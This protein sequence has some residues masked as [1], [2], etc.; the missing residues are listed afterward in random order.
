MSAVLVL[1]LIC[2]DMAMAHSWYYYLFGV[3]SIIDQ[4]LFW[5]HKSPR[6]ISKHL[7]SVN[8]SFIVLWYLWWCF[9]VIGG[10]NRQFLSFWGCFL[11]H[12]RYLEA[13]IQILL[14]S[15]SHLWSHKTVFEPK[16]LSLV[17]QGKR[18]PS[19]SWTVIFTWSTAVF[20]RLSPSF[21]PLQTHF[22]HLAW[23]QH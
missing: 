6:I 15:F 20:N 5:S 4:A 19:P 2:F 1:I 7:N 3:V 13:V 12:C 10:P 16:W 14:S 23:Y 9:D 21:K 18:K 11:H 17:A 8:V 22:G